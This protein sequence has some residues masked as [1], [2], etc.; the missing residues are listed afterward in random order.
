MVVASVSV[1]ISFS[2]A[3]VDATLDAAVPVDVTVDVEDAEHAGVSLRISNTVNDVSWS[4]R[5]P[6]SGRTI[7]ISSRGQGFKSSGLYYKHTIIINDASSIINKLE[8]MLTDDTRVIIYDRHVF[9]VQATGVLALR[10]SKG[11]AIFLKIFCYLFYLLFVLVNVLFIKSE[12]CQIHFSSWVCR[13]GVINKD[14]MDWLD[15]ARSP[16]VSF[17]GPALAWKLFPWSMN[18]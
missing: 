6:R 17:I 16:S 5:R 3:G 1:F 12:L 7:V 18:S 2:S 13:P 10:G 11:R 4:H 14:P 9:I 8:A 15:G